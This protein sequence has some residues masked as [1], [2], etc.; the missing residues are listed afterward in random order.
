MWVE[1][2][3]VGSNLAFSFVAFKQSFA[4]ILTA[5]DRNWLTSYPQFDLKVAVTKLTK[6]PTTEPRGFSRSSEQSS[7]VNR[8]DGRENARVGSGHRVTMPPGVD[9]VADTRRPLR[10][11]AGRP[12]PGPPAKNMWIMRDRGV[13]VAG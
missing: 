4:S 1:V 12:L 5:P 10:V 11:G 8:E 2:S 7:G 3:E 13:S 6:N 9:T